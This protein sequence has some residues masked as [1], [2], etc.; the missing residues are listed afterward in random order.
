M[1]SCVRDVEKRVQDLDDRLY[2]LEEHF[3]VEEQDEKKVYVKR[4]YPSK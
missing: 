4:R 1:K 2:D 3:L